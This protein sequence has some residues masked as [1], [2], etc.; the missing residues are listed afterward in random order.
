MHNFQTG[1]FKS[2]RRKAGALQRFFANPTAPQLNFLHE[3]AIQ[4]LGHDPSHF[5]GHQ[6]MPW[7]IPAPRHVLAYVAHATRQPKHE[8][9]RK[10]MDNTDVAK[11]ASG[12]ASTAG[13]L[14]SDAAE[15][16][17]SYVNSA[18]RFLAKHQGTI[19]SASHLANVGASIATLGGLIAPSTADRIHHATRYVV[20]KPKKDKS[21]GG[22]EDFA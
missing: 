7:K 5:W 15:A 4:H 12:W 18:A 9:Q 3:L 8:F 17:A 2:K 16:G 13:R 10:M 20:S 14:L 22:W 11:R 19:D 6:V 21:G 1:I